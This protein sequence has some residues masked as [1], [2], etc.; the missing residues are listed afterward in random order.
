[1]EE[2]PFQKSGEMVP[3]FLFPKEGYGGCGTT[4][5]GFLGVY[6]LESYPFQENLCQFLTKGN[7]WRGPLAVP[8]FKGSFLGV[9]FDFGFLGVNFTWNLSYF[10]ILMQSNCN[11][12][13]D[14][15]FLGRDLPF[16][17]QGCLECFGIMKFGFLGV[18]SS[19]HPAVSNVVQP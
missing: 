19:F 11:S 8:L 17:P 6:Y 3:P 16:S 12:I 4:K 14:L 5:I 18:N 15:D 13:G 10:M 2:A 9:W 1:M 7:L